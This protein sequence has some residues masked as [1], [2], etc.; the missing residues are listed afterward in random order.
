VVEDIKADARNRQGPAAVPAPPEPEPSPDA[1]SYRAASVELGWAKSV[2]Q[3]KFAE[4]IGDAERR[5]IESTIASA[6]QS[7]LSALAD[8]ARY[9]RRPALARRVLL[10]TRSRFGGSRSAVEAAFFLGRIVEDEGGD[11][12]KWYDRYLSESRHGAYAAQALGR[13]MM[14]VYGRQGAAGAKPIA[15]DYLRRYPKGPYASTAQRITEE[16]DRL[17]PSP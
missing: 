14:L 16:L 4:V 2:A 6:S 17:A 7:E 3:G 5:G 11:A 12:I 13:K 1:T 10:A 9:G 15:R 8:A